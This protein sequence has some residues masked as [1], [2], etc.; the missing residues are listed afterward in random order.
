MKKYGLTIL[1]AVI[2]GVLL[3]KLFFSQY[4][5]SKSL[6]TV[7]NK[8]ETLY[9][10]RQGIYSSL[11]SVK[12]NTMNLSYYIYN[13]VDDK[14]YVYYGITKD[15]ENY[16]KIAG[17]LKSLGYDNYRE[18]ITVSSDAFIETLEQYDLLLRETSDN[19]IIKAICAQVLAS[20]EELVL[21]GSEN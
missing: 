21:D 5:D 12:E 20:Y 9:F 19:T 13:I 15:L 18:E 17:N 2:T 8:G 16:E 1:L 14:Y 6:K 4:T 3:S 10:A 7:F 11:D